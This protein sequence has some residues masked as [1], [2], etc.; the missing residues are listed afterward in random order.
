MTAKGA[1]LE[2]DAGDVHPSLLLDAKGGA[3]ECNLDDLSADVPETLWV[4]LDYGLASSRAWLEERSGL[5]E[6]EVEALLAD[7]PRPRELVFG[8]ALLI[9]LR[10]V[11]LNEG[12]DPEDMISLRLYIEPSRVISVRRR[13]L[14]TVAV[15]R[16]QLAQGVGP[17]TVGELFISLVEGIVDR[18][19]DV[20][21]EVDDLSDELEDRVLDMEGRT[22]RPRLAMLR[23]KAISLRRYVAPQRDTIGRLP[24]ARVSW[25]ND[26]ERAE[27]REA[28]DRITRFVEDL[29]SARDRAAITMEELNNQLAEQMNHTMYRL[30]VVTAVFLPL[31]LLTGLFGINVA[32][33]PWTQNPYGFAFVSTILVGMAGLQLWWFRKLDWW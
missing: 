3:R 10:S 7:D 5:G 13:R 9:I 15:V 21:D 17:K 20:V 26:T 8:E 33:M 2:V 32:G 1:H 22:L 27:L 6:L 24:M 19:G 12:E 30:S 29:D 23:R 31:G 4:H 11:N 25:L 18:I 16:E 28:G 14:K